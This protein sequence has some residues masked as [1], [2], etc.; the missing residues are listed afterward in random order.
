VKLSLPCSFQP[1]VKTT[2]KASI[3]QRTLKSK[4]ISAQS[5]L[6]SIFATSSQNKSIS[7]QNKLESTSATLS[8]EKE[9]VSLS[10]PGNG[11]TVSDDANQRHL[12]SESTLRTDLS[13][14]IPR[15]KSSRRKSYTSSLIEGSKVFDA[16]MKLLVLF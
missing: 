12:P 5:K 13:E 2:L 11:S 8:Q 15:I 14:I 1:I 7:A 4:S 3:A 6:E 9:S 16:Q 10:L